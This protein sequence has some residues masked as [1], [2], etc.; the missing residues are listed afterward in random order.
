MDSVIFNQE[1][2]KGVYSGIMPCSISQF[3]RLG[4]L[5]PARLSNTNSIR[6]GGRS[7]DSGGGSSS[8]SHQD[9]HKSLLVLGS[10]SWA[11]AGWSARMSLNCCFSQGC[12]TAFGQL[13]TPLT[14]T[15]P[16]EG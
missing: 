12:R 3:T 11:G 4:V 5:W 8:P 9:S 14:R 13:V 6:S 7:S 10:K 16:S 15:C 1:P 2:P